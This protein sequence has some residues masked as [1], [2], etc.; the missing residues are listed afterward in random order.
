[1]RIY[2]IDF[3]SAPKPRKPLTVAVCTLEGS[4]LT[5]DGVDRLTNF[6]AFEQLLASPGPWVCGIDFPFG[7]PRRL[8]ENLQWPGTWE[9][10][11]SVVSS[12]SQQEFV[13]LLTEYKAPR[14][15]GDK[16]HRRETDKR[17]GAL[18]PM[19][20]FGVPVGKMFFEGAPR[21]LRSGASVLPM[22]E[23]NTER[24]IVEAYPALV[25][26]HLGQRQGYKNDKP[27]KQTPQ[28]RDARSL[29]VEGIRK[30]RLEKYAITITLDDNLA[31]EM[32]DEPTA[33]QLDSLLCAIQAAWAHMQRGPAYGIPE[34]AATNEGWIV[35][36]VLVPTAS[37]SR[38]DIGHSA[39]GAG[40]RKK[41]AQP[42]VVY[43]GVLKYAEI[44]E[45]IRLTPT[46]EIRRL[47]ETELRELAEV[48]DPGIEAR[49]PKGE[50]WAMAITLP[51]DDPRHTELAERTWGE[52][53]YMQYY[54][55]LRDLMWAIH[56]VL[57]VCGSGGIAVPYEMVHFPIPGGHFHKP[58]P[59]RYRVPWGIEKPYV[60]TQ[61]VAEKIARLI[62]DPFDPEEI[63]TIDPFT[64]FADAIYRHY[65]RDRWVDYIMCMEGILVPKEARR[66]TA[67]RFRQRGVLALAQNRNE[68]KLLRNRLGKWYGLRSA[69]VHGRGRAEQERFLHKLNL[70]YDDKSW[71]SLARQAEMYARDLLYLSLSGELTDADRREDFWQRSQRAGKLQAVPQA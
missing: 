71:T 17:A 66:K 69:I 31:N 33:D 12:M 60:L 13:D 48:R 28:Q 18:S 65:E 7:Q 41:I 43:L 61:S 38:T 24:I 36:P 40:R 68:K 35:D 64:R 42:G 67:N 34:S 16:E 56:V 30:G 25:A 49:F 22:L 50:E 9:G 51:R 58:V 10:Y 5:V 15:S 20:L 32:V 23:R 45:P 47:T 21:L 63:I 46:A 11:V 62:R 1:M 2:G 29:L 59:V 70:T 19:K 54:N 14:A 8:V 44:G 57:R 39:Q 53:Q 26:E 6:E 37:D 55:A 3:T 4:T 27:A 52:P